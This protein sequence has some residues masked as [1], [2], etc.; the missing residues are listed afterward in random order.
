MTNIQENSL[1][2]LQ[3]FN[4]FRVILGSM[5]IAAFLLSFTGLIATV[6]PYMLYPYIPYDS[7][8]SFTFFTQLLYM[9]ILIFCVGSFIGALIKK[10]K[11][12]WVFIWFFSANFL[13]LG[14]ETARFLIAKFPENFNYT[15][16]TLYTLAVLMITLY[17][18]KRWFNEKTPSSKPSDKR[19]I[20]KKAL[21]YGSFTFI[22]FW[23]IVLIAF[24]GSRD[25][26][27]NISQMSIIFLAVTLPFTASS[28]IETTIKDKKLK[29]FLIFGALSLLFLVSA[30]FLS[31]QIDSPY[32]MY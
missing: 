13:S 25:I 17:L 23:S 8:Q 5:A 16:V 1:T 31:V 7:G 12:R 3:N 6:A 21:I 22:V 4:I 27:Y 10:I 28:F 20:F 11:W 9:F 15:S 29:T 19:P 14:K 32:D 18:I 30:T 26:K 2:K 24:Y